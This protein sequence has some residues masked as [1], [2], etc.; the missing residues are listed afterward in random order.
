MPQQQATQL[1]QKQPKTSSEL[2]ALT[3]GALV[4]ELL[5]DLETPDLITTELD[6]MGHSMGLRAMEELLSQ[7]PD[8]NAT[9]FMD[10]SSVLQCAL[11]MFFG[12]SADVSNLT[13]TSYSLLFV[14]NPLTL[15]VELPDDD[16]TTAT[17]SSSDLEYC[18]LL[19]GWCRG[20]LEVLQM[21]CSC[22]F[23]Q[24]ALK[25]DAVN[26][27]SVSLNQILQDGAGEDYQEE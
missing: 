7:A 10:T 22:Q 26:E 20:C 1:W 23:A 15:F 17:S 13:A 18:A 14:D 3:Y 4:G 25:G 21:D 2:F 19:T 12:M 8:C 9:T 5:R 16:P 24:S 6:K 27:I 11:R